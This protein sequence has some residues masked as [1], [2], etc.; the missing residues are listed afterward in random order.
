MNNSPFHLPS[1]VM[2]GDFALMIKNT[3]GCPIFS[4]NMKTKQRAL[5]FLHF[6]VLA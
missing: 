2:G 5:L 6:T 4:T 1:F 3:P